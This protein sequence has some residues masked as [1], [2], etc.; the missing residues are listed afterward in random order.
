MVMGRQLVSSQ[1]ELP[2]SGSKSTSTSDGL[3]DPDISDFT[4]VI[5]EADDAPTDPLGHKSG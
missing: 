4:R 5:K 3:G 2:F 1:H